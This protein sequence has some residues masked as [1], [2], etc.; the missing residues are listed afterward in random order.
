MTRSP[1]RQVVVFLSRDEWQR[2][3]AQAAAA[4]RDPYQ[5]ARW[6]L[7]QELGEIKR[8]TEPVEAA[9]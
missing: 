2:L 7:L 3:A 1:R 8:H 6:I 5:Q 4:E 9:S